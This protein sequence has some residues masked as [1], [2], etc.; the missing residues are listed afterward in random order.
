MSGCDRG[1]PTSSVPEPAPRALSLLV[2]LCVRVVSVL[3][4]LPAGQGACRFVGGTW[5]MLLSCEERVPDQVGAASVLVGTRRR[6]S[7]ISLFWSSQ[8]FTEFG[9]HCGTCSFHGTQASACALLAPK[10]EW[11]CPVDRQPVGSWKSLESPCGWNDK[12][13][14]LGVS[15]LPVS[16]R[17]NIISH[18][19]SE[20]S[21]TNPLRPLL[22]VS[23]FLS[24]VSRQNGVSHN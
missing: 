14:P 22:L 8:S 5:R 20:W 16:V 15:H 21:F 2:F 3:R 12:G 13:Y 7:W 9:E 19:L 17:V 4:V 23:R 18:F 10:F 24:K 1:T 11:P 6:I